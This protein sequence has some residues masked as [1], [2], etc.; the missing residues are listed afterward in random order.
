MRSMEPGA[1]DLE[2]IEALVDLAPLAQAVRDALA[3]IPPGQAEAVRL[4]IA[5]ERSYTEVASMLG[6]TEGA[7]RVRVS[8]GLSALAD[9]MG[10]A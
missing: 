8:R 1:Q 7:A 2:R 5:E 9:L 4:R 3:R 10:E 6:C